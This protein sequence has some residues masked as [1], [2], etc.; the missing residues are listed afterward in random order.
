VVGALLIVTVVFNEW[1][2]RRKGVH[3]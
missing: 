3:A 1:M 2:V